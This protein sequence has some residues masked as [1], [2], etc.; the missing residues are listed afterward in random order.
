MLLDPGNLPEDF[1]ND[2][3]S[4]I[5]ILSSQENPDEFMEKSRRLFSNLNRYAKPTDHATNII[6]DE[7]DTFA[8]LTRRLVTKHAFFKSAGRQR[9]SK[10]IKTQKGKNLKTGDPYFTSL[11]TLYEMNVELLYSQQRENDGWGQK[12]EDLKTF[13]RF[14]P[15]EEYIDSLY[16]ELEMY[17]DALLVEIPDLRK[18]PTQM[19]THE[20]PDWRNEDK[21]DHLLFWPIGQQMLAEITR[22]L[23][24]KRLPDPENPKPETV[25]A[26]LSGLNQLEWRLHQTPWQYF[27]LVRNAKDNWAMRSEERKV[28]ISRG[29][30]IQQ[31]VIGL[32]EIDESGVEELKTLWESML[33]PA[34]SKEAQ[35]E[36]WQQV[37]D[38]KS[39]ISE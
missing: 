18:E 3:I 17:W 27:L 1:E 37:E 22:A 33:I 14:R 38:R 2:E 35:D 19:R 23:L 4:V 28:A 12:G 15:S 6:M 11:E 34:Q 13:K 29:R 36:M 24:N 31:W 25:R 16:T 30:R 5:V 7:D 32:D 10:H 8:I 26:A 39:A 9:E 20:L 21:T